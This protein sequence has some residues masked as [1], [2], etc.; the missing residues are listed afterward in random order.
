MG[1]ALCCNLLG[2]T[3]ASSKPCHPPFLLPSRIEAA[4]RN[5]Q[6]SFDLFPVLS[7]LS[8]H[9]P[10]SLA[11]PSLFL[12]PAQWMSHCPSSPPYC[13]LFF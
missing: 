1:K 7:P 13:H 6:D 5:S 3:E 12:P 2:N 8:V 10:P 11:S 9:L 4:E